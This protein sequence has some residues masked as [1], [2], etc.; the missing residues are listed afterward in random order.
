MVFVHL[1]RVRE[2]V[3]KTRLNRMTVMPYYDTNSHK[4]TSTSTQQQKSN[5]T[6]LTLR[7]ME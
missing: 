1:I 2:S 7:L 6:R 3:I 4:S 5:Y